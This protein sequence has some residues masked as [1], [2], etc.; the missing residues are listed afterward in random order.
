MGVFDTLHQQSIVLSNE[1]N[2]SPG[3]PKHGTENGGEYNIYPPIV[4]P[5]C[6]GFRGGIFVQRVPCGS[7]QLVCVYDVHLLPLD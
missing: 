4:V 2:H 7:R 1:Q 6:S 5:V 3:W